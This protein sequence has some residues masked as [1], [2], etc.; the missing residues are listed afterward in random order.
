MLSSLEAS[1]AGL[2]SKLRS[3][4]IVLRMSLRMTESWHRLWNVEMLYAGEPW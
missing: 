3:V 4:Y 2:E 1:S